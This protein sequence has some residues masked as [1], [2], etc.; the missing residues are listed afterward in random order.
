M[1]WSIGLISNTPKI[2][3]ACAKDL[4]KATGDEYFYDLDDVTYKGHLQFNEDH[5]EHMDY[6]QDERVIAVLRKHKVEGDITFGSLEGDNDGSFWGYRF[7]GKGG[8]KF[9]EGKVV[10]TET[11]QQPEEPEPGPDDNFIAQ[12]VKTYSLDYTEGTSDKVYLIYVNQVGAEL[13][14][15]AYEYGR[16][17]NKMTPGIRASKISRDVAF[18]VADSLAAEKRKKGYVLRSTEM[19]ASHGHA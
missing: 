18:Q 1:S 12:T 2:T 10:F 17:G 5:Q 13:Y 3:T 6:V 11:D 14:D 7:D 15:V 9:L 16:R 4:I 8:I 19:A